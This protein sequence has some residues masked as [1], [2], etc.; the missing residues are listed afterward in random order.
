MPAGH[1]RLLQIGLGALVLAGSAAVAVVL[2]MAAPQPQK[3]EEIAAV[4]LVR[5]HMADRVDLPVTV[6]GYGEVRAAV[7]AKIIPQVGGRVL[8]IHR[9]LHTGGFVPAG[10]P[11]LVID[12]TDFELAQQS[13]QADIAAAQAGL[14]RAEANVAEARVTVADEAE[15]L[16]IARQLHAQGGA[17]DREVGKA[18]VEHEQAEAMLQAS[19]AAVASAE[20]QLAASRIAAERAAVDLARTRLTL[21][22]DAVI[23]EETVDL[24]QHLPS[25]QSVGEAYGTAA[26]EVVVPL[27]D[28]ELGWLSTLPL[29]AVAGPASD[30]ESLPRA[31]IEAEFAGRSCTWEGRA[32]RTEGEI[33]PLS[34]MV[35]VIVQVER[36]FAVNDQRPPLM[37]G[38]FV[39]VAIDGRELEGVVA[40]PR[41]SLRE[42]K[43]VWVV[44]GGKLRIRP[45]QIIR[46]EREHIYI[47]GGVEPGEAVVVTPLDVAI[48]GMSVRIAQA[49]SQEPAATGEPHLQESSGG[50]G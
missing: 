43:T 25:G 40:L 48:D 27:E 34:R 15:D 13:A 28:R 5:V 45:V 7:R 42:N 14:E 38:A 9:G 3:H 31:Q 23:V 1:H 16:R 32:V 47:T 4:P 36:P 41:E 22:F 6:R 35:R 24:G 19:Q 12:P 33:D 49:P 30:P 44:D 10:E 37:P 8:E 46:S 17:T 39:R 2:V 11:L 50:R 20:A 26:V 18:R 29:T 21:P